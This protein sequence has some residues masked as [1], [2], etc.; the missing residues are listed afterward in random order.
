MR[1]NSADIFFMSLIFFNRSVFAKKIGVWIGCKKRFNLFF[2][3]C[4]F[5]C[6][7]SAPTLAVQVVREGETVSVSVLGSPAGA[8]TSGQSVQVYPAKRDNQDDKSIRKGGDRANNVSAVAGRVYLAAG[9]NLSDFV[10]PPKGYETVSNEKNSNDKSGD[11]SRVEPVDAT[12][13]LD[14]IPI[15]KI[16]QN[17]APVTTDRSNPQWELIRQ[18][19]TLQQEVSELRGKLEQQAQQISVMESQQKQRY[20]DLD[21]RLEALQGSISISSAGVQSTQ[22]K[23]EMVSD[24]RIGD[25]DPVSSPSSNQSVAVKQADSTNAD[26]MLKAY[27]AAQQLLKEKKL[28][29]AKTAFNQFTKDFPESNLTGD[30][31]YWLGEIYLASQPSQ[32]AAAKTE[33]SKVVDYFADSKKVPHALYKLALLEIRGGSKTRAKTLLLKLRKDHPTSAPAKLVDAQLKYLKDNP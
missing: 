20:L 1:I 19:S 32:E 16:N 31:H 27:E 5:Q 23:A 28:K 25:V 22:Q 2:Y 7:Y 4:F 24:E 6:I 11:F 17:S 30:A 8:S 9:D 3:V 21:S 26:G 13:T 14:Q 29:S 10:D 18:L 15:D 12:V 33:F